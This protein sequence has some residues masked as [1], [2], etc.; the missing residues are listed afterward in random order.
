MFNCN[1][2]IN[3]KIVYYDTCDFSGPSLHGMKL[4]AERSEDGNSRRA[5]DH[6]ATGT[7]TPFS[8]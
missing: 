5:M 1:Q 4:A 8:Y 6:S 2:I 7:D 3:H